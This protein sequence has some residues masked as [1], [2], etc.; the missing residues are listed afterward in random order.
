MRF[1][2][3]ITARVDDLKIKRTTE[4]QKFYFC[5]ESVRFVFAYGKVDVWRE[6]GREGG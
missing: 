2:Y 3:A 6:R 1:L 4:W 5:P